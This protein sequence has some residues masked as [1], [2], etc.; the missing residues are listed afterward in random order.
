MIRA[1]LGALVAIPTTA[2]AINPQHV[3]V[4]SEKPIRLANT[5]SVKEFRRRVKAYEQRAELEEFLAK[6]CERVMEVCNRKLIY[7]GPG[8]KAPHPTEIGSS[9]SIVQPNVNDQNFRDFYPPILAQVILS[10]GKHAAGPVRK[11]QI[12]IDPC[13]SSRI[14]IVAHIG[15]PPQWE[16]RW[17]DVFEPFFQV[18]CGVLE[19]KQWILSEREIGTCWE[20]NPMWE[21]ARYYEGHDGKPTL[22]VRHGGQPIV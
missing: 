15:E 21:Q 14:M 19:V 17:I 16:K 7:R 3:F 1:T 5:I 20:L 2:P 11:M 10:V 4:K 12:E 8:A 6:E 18:G 13:N 22:R 9:V